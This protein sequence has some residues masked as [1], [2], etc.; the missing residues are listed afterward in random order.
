MNGYP[1][2]VTL[3]GVQNQF[4]SDNQV[5]TPALAVPAVPATPLTR[6]RRRSSE[7]ELH[8][9]VG[10]HPVRRPDEQ[11]GRRAVQP[12]RHLHLLQRD[13]PHGGAVPEGVRRAP[14]RSARPRPPRL[15]GPDELRV[16]EHSRPRGP[17][18]SLP[19]L[20]DLQCLLD[21]TRRSRPRPGVRLRPESQHDY[22]GPVERIGDLELLGSAGNQR[23][24]LV[25][26]LEEAQARG[27]TVLA[28]SGDSGD[29]LRAPGG[30]G[31]R[32]TPARWRSTTS[33]MSRS[34]GRRT[35]SRGRPSHSSTSTSGTMPRRPRAGRLH[36]GGQLALRRTLLAGNHVGGQRDRG[37]RSGRARPVS[38]RQQL[39][40]D[41]HL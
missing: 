1:A 37:G 7:R 14:R 20:Y 2:P 31:T 32:S 38:D 28:I 36:R 41:V 19:R 13:P 5:R 29:S 11:P 23:H 4:I 34:A 8:G 10:H 39:S 22:P 9:G 30:S 3:G 26:D 40:H 33:G 12:E 16:R 35:P 17:R 21:R 15:L 25:P 27:I 24:G 6:S 18:R